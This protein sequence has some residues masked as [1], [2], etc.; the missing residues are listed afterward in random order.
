MEISST[1]CWQA[2]ALYNRQKP[3]NRCIIA[4]VLIYKLTYRRLTHPVKDKS[5]E[6]HK[7]LENI[8][9]SCL[10]L[11][12]ADGEMRAGCASVN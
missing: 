4:L 11:S 8:K 10:L 2:G 6:Y 9:Y 5:P 7:Q 3:A 1:Y 12:R